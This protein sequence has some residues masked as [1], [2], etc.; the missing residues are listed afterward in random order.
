LGAV[1]VYR[2]KDVLNDQ[3][4]P[5]EQERLEA[6]RK[7]AGQA[8]IQTEIS[9]M[10]QGLHMAKHV[11]GTRNKKH[12]MKIQVVRDGYANVVCNLEPNVDVLMMTAA[13][14]YGQASSRTRRR[15]TIYLDVLENQR[16][17]E[18]E[19]VTRMISPALQHT[20]DQAV[21]LHG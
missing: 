9:G 14:Y 21:S 5:E 17:T 11:E 20:L 12:P 3:Q 13:F 19:E 15:P 1:P 8:F 10:N 18:P 7:Q 16:R 6:I 2:R 4:T